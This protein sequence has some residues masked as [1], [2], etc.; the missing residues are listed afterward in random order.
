LEKYSLLDEMKD[1]TSNVDRCLGCSRTEKFN[2]KWNDFL[3]DYSKNIIKQ[4]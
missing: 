1:G 2:L 4:L 3:I